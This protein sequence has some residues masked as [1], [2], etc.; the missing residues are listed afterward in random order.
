[1]KALGRNLIIQKTKEKVKKEIERLLREQQGIEI[2]AEEEVEKE[3]KKV[4]LWN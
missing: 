4:I 2:P 3:A 1:M